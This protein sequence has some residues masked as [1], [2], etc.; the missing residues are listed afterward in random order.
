MWSWVVASWV[1][2][3]VV[4]RNSCESWQCSCG[5]ESWHSSIVFSI[6]LRIWGMSLGGSAFENSFLVQEEDRCL[7]HENDLRVVHV[8]DFLVQHIILCLVHKQRSCSSY[9]RVNSPYSS[10]SRI[11]IS[12]NS[13]GVIVFRKVRGILGRLLNA[14][15][16]LSREG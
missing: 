6:C 1:S 14:I 15:V 16:V 8:I 2:V 11:F 5:R 4:A 9:T 3:V 10:T 12:Y 7:V 13:L